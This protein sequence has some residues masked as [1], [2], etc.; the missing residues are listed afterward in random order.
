M[1]DCIFCK[2]GRGEIPAKVVWESDTLLAFDDIAP[3]APVHTLLIPRAHYDAL[4]DAPRSLLGELIAAV[5]EVAGVKGVAQSGYRTIVNSGADAGQTV[6]HLHVH[7]LGGC[8]MSEG[9]VA[10]ACDS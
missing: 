8:A 9:M 4:A 10:L 3:Q 5:P 2:I 7:I 6:P 1:K